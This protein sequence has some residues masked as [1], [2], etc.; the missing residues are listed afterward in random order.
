MPIG[1]SLLPCERCSVHSTNTCRPFEA[2]PQ[3]EFRGAPVR[4]HWAPRRLLFRAGDALGPVF[5]ITTGIVG[6]FAALPDGRR[7]LIRFLG[8]GAICGYLSEKGC[9]AFDGEAITTVQACSFARGSFDVSVTHDAAFAE[10]LRAQMSAAFEELGVHMTVLGQLDSIE[11]VA[12][13][14]LKMREASHACGS[15][16][17][18][19][20][21]PM[22][23]RQIAN[24]LGLRAETVSRAFNELR[25]RQLIVPQGDAVTIIDLAGLAASA[26]RSTVE[27]KP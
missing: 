12:D 20:R 21:L 11:R 27:A 1:L 17:S 10:A 22:K 18:S 14:L 7:Q 5:K 3:A 16:T 4:E 9:Y 6:L 15:E 26:G 13:F 19:L 25:R 24:Y 2:Q 23:S 8:P